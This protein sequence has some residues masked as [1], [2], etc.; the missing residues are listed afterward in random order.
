MSPGRRS[1]KTCPRDAALDLLNANWLCGVPG[2][3]KNVRRPGDIYERA[4]SPGQIFLPSSHQLQ[5]VEYRPMHAGAREIA[6]GEGNN[7]G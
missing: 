4:A 1:T 6:V 2:T 7:A 3:F 5:Q